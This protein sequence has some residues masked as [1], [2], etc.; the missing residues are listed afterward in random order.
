[1]E[2]PLWQ[3]AALE[4]DAPFGTDRLDAHR[5]NGCRVWGHAEQAGPDRRNRRT[6][7][8]TGISDLKRPRGEH[9]VPRFE[10]YTE[11]ADR[12][13]RF[14]TRQPRSQGYVAPCR[15]YGCRPCETRHG[16]SEAPHDARYPSSEV[17]PRSSG[18]PH[19]HG[20]DSLS[21]QS[22]R[23][24][25]L[26]TL[27]LWRLPDQIAAAEIR[28]GRR[29][30]SHRCFC[31]PPKRGASV[32]SPTVILSGAGNV[33]ANR[34]GL[35]PLNTRAAHLRHGAQVAGDTGI[36]DSPDS[37]VAPSAMAFTGPGSGPDT[38]TGGGAS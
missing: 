4:I 36:G 30:G 32:I 11:T 31:L 22:L 37:G 21:G 25:A 35:A 14:A 9:P 10:S 3:R 13:C 1:M 38:K 20:M 23:G 27:P 2:T 7:E 16:V 28:A 8:R 24:R 33:V 17:Y 6:V 18:F 15:Q 5:C 19:T 34:S 12:M 29:E 26:A